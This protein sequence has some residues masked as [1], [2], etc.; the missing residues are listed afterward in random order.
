MLP[1][2]RAHTGIA[3]SAAAEPAASDFEALEKLRRLAFADQ[4]DAPRQLDLWK[5][6]AAE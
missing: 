2:S 6:E 5:Q 1:P 3:P 4:I